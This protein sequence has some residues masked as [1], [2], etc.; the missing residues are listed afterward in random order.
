MDPGLERSGSRGAGSVARRARGRSAARPRRDPVAQDPLGDRV[1]GVTDLVHQDG[2]RLPVSPAGLLD[3][4]SIHLGLR[5]AGP[6]RPDHQ[7]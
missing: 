2:E 6:C 3:E 5:W 1:E 4:V 7:L